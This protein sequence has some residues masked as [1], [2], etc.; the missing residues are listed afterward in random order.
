MLNISYAAETIMETEIFQRFFSAD[1]P[2]EHGML[3][4]SVESQLNLLGCTNFYVGWERAIQESV[5]DRLPGPYVKQKFLE[6]LGHVNKAHLTYH[7]E[8]Y[9]WHALCCGLICSHYA[10]VYGV[11]PKVAFLLGFLHDIGKPFTETRSGKT[12]MHGQIGVHLAETVLGD[13][14]ADMRQVLLFLI[15]QHMCVCTHT[16]EERHHICFATLQNMINSYSEKQ[17]KLYGAYYRCLVYGDRL[18][19]YRPDIHLDMEKVKHIESSTVQYI[20][21]GKP[22]TPPVG[23]GNMYL[24]MHGAPG[25]GKSTMAA[26]FTEALSAAGLTVGVAERDQAYWIV[27]RKQK[28]VPLELSF[29]DFVEKTVDFGGEEGPNTYYKHVYPQ[30]KTQIAEHYRNIVLDAAEKYDVVILDSCVSLNPKV[31]GDFIGTEDNMYVWTGFPQHL[32]GRKGS[33]KVEEQS[34]YPLEQECAYYRSAVEIYKEP[35]SAPTPLVASSCFQE[36]YNLVVASWR[37]KLERGVEHVGEQ[38]YPSVAIN[39]GGLAEFK[40]RNPMVVVDEGLKFYKH[41]SY[42]VIRLS[43]YDGKQHG[44]GSTLHYRGEHLIAGADADANW[45]PLR[46]SLPV[47]PETSQLR[48]FHSHA[49]LYGFVEPLKKYLACE[50]TEPRTRVDPAAVRYNRCFVLPKVDGS[51]M[52]VSAVKAA[53]VQGDYIRYLKDRHSVGEFYREIE[54]VIYYVGSKSCLF[55]TQASSVVEPFKAAV[56]ASYGSFDAFYEQVHAHLR[57][58][59][60][61]ETASVVFEAVPEHPYWGLTVDYG[62]SFVTHLATVYYKGEGV[63][64]ELPSA[65]PG[66]ASPLHA[67]PVEEIPCSAE[68][69]ESYYVKKMEEALQGSVEDLE[70]FMLAFTEPAGGLLYMKLKFPWYYAAHKP[71]IHFQEAERLYVDPKYAR[72]KDRL[73]GLQVAVH[74]AE[75]KKNPGLVFEEFAG[76]LIN[77]FD[78]MKRPGDSR[79]DFMVRL[80]GSGVGPQG[81]RPQGVSA[82]E[83]AL[84]HEDE[85]EDAFKAILSKFYIKAEFNLRKHIASLYDVLGSD[86]KPKKV[87]AI[88]TFYIKLLKL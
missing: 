46:V 57:A 64:I 36:L 82:L 51:L 63:R 68:A 5:L 55:A 18:G 30:I 1:T 13:L 40:R 71:D 15:D 81:V 80:F 49:E 3:I 44:N 52:N 61:E 17:R 75:L 32:L 87:A 8:P 4:P 10:G 85:L 39:A 20:L 6:T 74:A 53:S 60:W 26:R 76:L 23:P 83:D 33:Y 19:A 27:A 42:S 14:D 56:V 45:L 54:G 78:K 59:A 65:A 7:H 35:E 41:P 86:D 21:Q 22:L 24:V 48:K 73:F 88:T 66:T 29:E 28:L 70:G 77:C 84:P 58:V 72:I 50:F 9:G 38:V 79:K 34:V 37:V 11:S 12:Y 16:P 25:C 31:L 43:Y 2:T 67:A 47:T 69:I 62:R